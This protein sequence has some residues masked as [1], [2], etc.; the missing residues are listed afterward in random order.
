M[1]LMYAT[2]TQRVRRRGRRSDQ[3][4]KFANR[5]ETELTALVM[6]N[7]GNS[8]AAIC[9]VRALPAGSLGPR[10]NAPP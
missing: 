7:A 8:P 3:I 2:D 10:A 9:R 1:N 6:R 5:L 4:S